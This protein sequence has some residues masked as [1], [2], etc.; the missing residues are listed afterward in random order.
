MW[1]THNEALLTFARTY[2]E[3]TLAVSL[4]M[5]QSGFPVIR[6]VNQRWGLG[7]TEV[8]TSE[9]FDPTVTGRRPGR[10]PLSDRRLIDR[11]DATWQALERLR[12][13]TEQMIEEAKV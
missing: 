10:Q 12:E 3:D 1:L 2:P 11:V 13:Q 9:V 7:L 8:P 6:A 4:E 5:V